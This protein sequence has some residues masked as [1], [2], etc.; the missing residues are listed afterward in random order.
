MLEF[1]L[2]IIFYC[3]QIV[4][5]S[6]WIFNYFELVFG[7]GSFKYQTKI[8]IKKTQTEIST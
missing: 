1:F 6:Y 2:I 8:E 5:W 7:I 3:F 4:F